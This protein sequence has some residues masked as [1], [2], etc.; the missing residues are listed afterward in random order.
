MNI[1]YNTFISL[2][3]TG[4][5][6]AASFNPKAKLW[7][8]G[9]KNWKNKLKNAISTNDKVIWMHCSSL[10]EF[11]QGRP[12]MEKIRNEFPDHKLA[13]SFFSPSGYEIRKD[14]KG[15]DYIFYLPLD[16]QKN[17][18]N[19]IKFLHP[20]VLILVKYE[21]WYN[22]LNRLEK[23]KIPVIVISAVIK[24][25]NL[26]FRPFGS[27]FQKIIA[28]INHFFVQDQDSKNL[29]ESIGI[30]QVTISGDTRFDR[31]KEILASEPKLEF[32]EKFKSDKKLIVAGSTWSDDESILVNFINS[33]LPE[34]WKVIFAPHN[35][36]E[37]EIKSLAEKIEK[38]VAIYTKSNAS[39]IEKAQVLI[40]DTIG[41]LTKIYAYSDISYVGGGFTKT[42]VHNTLEPAV[43]GVP[44]IFGPNYEK[45]FEAIDLLENQGAIRFVDQFDF[46]EKMENLIEDNMERIRRGDAAQ[47]YIQQ[48]P[49]ST[50]LIMN[51]LNNLISN[52]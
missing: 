13:V 29:L 24:E 3:G 51:Y 32:V 43:F 27:W 14:Y 41:M 25:D 16:T 31:V 22:L 17:A 33:K 7:K 39:E 28:S 42:G 46:D 36:H 45:Y 52:P 21:Y 15:A 6:V 8:S 37:K 23:K 30:R 40:V 20:E 9:R 50:A 5:S 44:V 10:G 48:K 49:N 2:Y 12:V 47:N 11:E 18:K 26:F 35:I 38:P 4:I 19:L 34:N 1:I